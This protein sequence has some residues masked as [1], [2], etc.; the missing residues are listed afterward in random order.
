MGFTFVYAYEQAKSGFQDQVG[1]NAAGVA[2]VVRS[3]VAGAITVADQQLGIWI[4]QHD[5]KNAP[6]V[7][8]QTLSIFALLQKRFRSFLTGQR[9]L[10]PIFSAILSVRP[11]EVPEGEIAPPVRSAHTLF[12]SSP[13]M[14]D[15]DIIKDFWVS[16]E[17]GHLSVNSR[18]RWG[19]QE[20]I[21]RI[22]GPSPFAKEKTVL[23]I[24][25]EYHDIDGNLVALAGLIDW[26]EVQKLIE[27]TAVGGQRLG[28]LARA[29]DTY[30]VVADQ[31]GTVLGGTVPAHIFHDGKVTQLIERFASDASKHQRFDIEGLGDCLVGLEMA[32]E[33]G[34]RI[35]SI[36]NAEIAMAP[37]RRLRNANIAASVLLLLVILGLSLQLTGR[38]TAPVKKLVEGTQLA[39]D[40]NLAHKIDI[41]S[42]DEIGELAASFNTMIQR[43]RD[44]FAQ[45]GEQ[46]EQLKKLDQLKDQFLA[47]TSHEL[48]T[49]INGVIGLLGAMLEGAY[50]PVNEG[51]RPTLELAL[52][53]GKRLATL[54]NGILDFSAAKQGKDELKI[55]RVD[56][57]KLIEGELK[58]LFEGLNR[59]KGLTLS[60][61]VDPAVPV[62]EADE[63][64]VRQMVMNLGGNAIKFTRQGSVS[65]DCTLDAGGQ[66]V[67]IRIA[68]TGIGIAKENL[69]AIFEPFRQ[70][71]G[72]SN[73]EFEGTGLGLTIVKT[74]AERHGGRVWVESTLGQ[75][76]TFNIDLPI[77]QEGGV[78]VSAEAPTPAPAK[79][80]DS[81]G[82]LPVESSPAAPAL[83]ALPVMPKADAPSTKGPTESIINANKTPAPGP[84]T[85]LFDIRGGNGELIWV[86][87]DEPVNIEVVRARLDMYN[88]KVGSFTSAIAALE[89]LKNTQRLPDLILLD[90][91]MPGMD[92]YQFCAKVKENKDHSAIPIIMI[93]A[94]TQLIDKIYGL[95]LGALDYM[96]KP[97]EREELLSKIRTFLDLQAGK[98]MKAELEMA[99]A[100]QSMLV[101]AEHIDGPRCS[102][103]SKMSSC[104]ETGGDWFT[105]LDSSENET[106]TAI[107][108]DVSGH[109]APAAL[110]TGLLHGFF[111]AIRDQVTASDKNDWQAHVDRALQKLNLTVIHATQRKLAQSLFL[112]AFDHRTRK[113]R[114]CNAGH[115][116][117]VMVTSNDGAAKVT[118]LLSP[119]SSLI[120]DNEAPT[121]SWGEMQ[122]S[123]GD[124]FLLYTDGLVECTNRATKPYGARRLHKILD[125]ATGLEAGQV[126]DLVLEDAFAFYG[127]MPRADDITVIAGKVR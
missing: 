37:I 56:L 79:T 39:A 120:G 49:P 12:A 113:A 53:S 2:H 112:F 19:G 57:R 17:D 36:R 18:Y 40:G 60:F 25:R 28:E 43:L 42:N 59:T 21:G 44:S 97:F 63:E 5:A 24:A 48:R 104:T 33:G 75:G 65:V 88:Y 69:D 93:S 83:P 105:I 76:S 92:G 98:R 96:T 85:A 62:I 70:V 80:A 116:H 15:K 55:S 119:P 101:S 61:K 125:R 6:R 51:L 45:L 77:K 22:L 103:A 127:D 109:G 41:H 84:A 117:P 1:Q 106:T 67:I 31:S 34:M 91:M 47:N 110:V 38:I 74:H 94:K 14:E 102:F 8:G 29:N 114:F 73:R 35:L 121:F 52:K 100:I 3:R 95:N 123:A 4:T 111:S 126:R 107:V 7:Y 66:R 124:S 86:I 26:A 9:E 13:E 16:G 54:V 82:A 99:S 50:G 11:A 58:P 32:P 118:T 68:D 71:E 115:P 90:I 78:T 122:F 27:E 89:E 64:K 72:Q 108:A 23:P 10:L 81:S 46:N 20:Q 87:D 30:V